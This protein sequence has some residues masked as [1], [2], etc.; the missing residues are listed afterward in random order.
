[1]KY[2]TRHIVITHTARVARII[3]HPARRVSN[4]IFAG[5]V[6][7]ML[8]TD[9]PSIYIY[10]YIT[11]MIRTYLHII[12]VLYHKIYQRMVFRFYSSYFFPVRRGA[13]V[14]RCRAMCA[15]RHT[16]VYMQCVSVCECVCVCYDDRFRVGKIMFTR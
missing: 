3:I 4:K 13:V 12:I 2:R 10:I 8:Q 15:L 11:V 5:H 7:M 16:R 1:M 6:L 14:P 9:N